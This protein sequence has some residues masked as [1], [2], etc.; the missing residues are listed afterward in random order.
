MRSPIPIILAT[1]GLI[2][3]GILAWLPV[4][5]DSGDPPRHPVEFSADLAES[6]AAETATT[7][8]GEP[9]EPLARLLAAPLISLERGAVAALFDLGKG[10]VVSL[11]LPGSPQAEAVMRHRHDGGAIAI[12]F[13]LKGEAGATLFL[14]RSS[15]GVIEGHLSSLR[16]GSAFRLEDGTGDDPPR[17]RSIAADELICARFDGG[18]LQPGLPPDPESAEVADGSSAAPEE[19]APLLESR[20][21]ASRVIYLNF[22][23]ETVTGTPWNL[24][25]NDGNP[26]VAAAF[27]TP[28]H[29]PGIWASIAEDYATFDVNVTTDRADFDNAAPED[30]IMILFSPTKSWYGSAGG[31]AYVNSFGSATNPYAWVF[32]LTLNGAA[33]SGAHEIGHT[34]GL[35]HDGTSSRAYY[36]GHTHASG[37]S[38][39]PIMGTGYGKTIVQFSKGEYPGANRTENDLEIMA[40]HLDPLPDDHG[41]SA[42]TATEPVPSAPGEI[43]ATGVV[44]NATDRDLFRLVTGGAGTLTAT[45]TPHATYRNLDLRLELLDENLVQIQDSAPAGPFDATLAVPALPAG[46]Y[47]L[48]V[49]GT[50]LGDL[51]TGYGTYGS[52]GTYRLAANFPTS[53]RPDTPTNPEAGDGTSTSFVPL[54]WDPSPLADSYRVYRGLLSNGSD[55][56]LV[57]SPTGTSFD[58]TTAVPGTVYFYF[59]TAANT[60]GE[61]PRS[62]GE[63]GWRQRLPPDPVA[64]VT[65]SDDS[66]HSIRVAWPA[67]DRA[68]SYRVSRNAVNAFAG[69]TVVGTTSAISWH[70]TTTAV[71][72]TF[73]YFIE[74]INTGGTSAP[75]ATTLPGRKTPLPP[76][77]PT[78]L[79]A[80]DGVSPT[81]TEL[82]WTAAAGA[83]GY[84]VYRNTVE[85]VA[86]A[87]EIAVLG[88]TT[89][90]ADAGGTRGV[91][92]W[93]FVRAILAGGDSAPSNLD[94]G[95][96]LAA[97]PGA[98]V[99]VT[100]TRGTNPGGVL[101]SWGATGDTESYRIY[102]GSETD[103]GSAEFLGETSGLEWLD[104]TAAPGRTYHYFVRS[105]NTAGS[106]THSAAVLGYGTE[107]DP[108]DDGYEN[109]DDVSEATAITSGEIAA[110]GIDGDPDWYAV[111][112][113]PG[114]SRLDLAVPYAA[115]LGSVLLALCDE[116]GTTVATATAANSSRVL[117]HT[118]VAAASYR[119]LVECD[120]GAAVPYRLI[121]SPLAPGQ[122]GISPDGAIGATLP[123]RIGEAIRNAD[124]AGQTLRLVKRGPGSLRFFASLANRSAV[125]GTFMTRGRGASH[126]LEIGYLRIIDGRWT[127]VTGAVTSIGLPSSLPPFASKSFM[128]T[129]RETGSKR[130]RRDLHTLIPLTHEVA[131]D[132]ATLDRVLCHLVR[133]PPRRR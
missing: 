38:W 2:A 94:E 91:V 83:T 27:G 65:A 128:V 32:N 85:S 106:S 58:D 41:D 70:D 77:T 88:E 18:Q 104:D 68:Q 16:S 29:I 107:V 8:A 114:V 127:P 21:S 4:S 28:A 96:R 5:R 97:P 25:Y 14:S 10:A 130:S 81:Q 19:S 64:S 74:S 24:S 52:I 99:S 90:H 121:V 89:A 110:V 54:S 119:V 113:G 22:D 39:A 80:S 133:R 78:G 30:R 43:E 7:H 115:S 109:N 51:V 59:I 50:G 100:G 11:P 40:T 55:A 73:H 44:G 36:T 1:C 62:S 118:G 35:R 108:S 93:Y 49:R 103:P 69:S 15:G 6:G 117:S 84:R 53:P 102:R 120:E 33:E 34:L 37:V 129:V 124:G 75:V 47:F 60:S 123:P 17:L 105:V 131:E 26:I 132:T 122:H 125:A 95:R 12:G 67:A 46:T 112:L 92:Y 13:R 98:P 72:A 20:P 101:L 56:T 3:A 48:R 76:G 57:A 82:T 111:T 66:P 45:A 9:S 126:A 86:G 61:S 71:N 79:Y 116:N 23:G 31:V 42:A 63:S 87:T